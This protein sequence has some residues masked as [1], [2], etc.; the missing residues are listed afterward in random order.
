MWMQHYE[1]N[2]IYSRAQEYQFSLH[3]QNK[4]GYL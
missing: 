2:E 3:V 1:I 4:L